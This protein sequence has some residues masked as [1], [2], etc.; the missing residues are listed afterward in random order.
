MTILETTNIQKTIEQAQDT[1]LTKAGISSL[2]SRWTL[3]E[4]ELADVV[5]FLRE[6]SDGHSIAA[7]LLAHAA[8]GKKL[9]AKVVG[10]ALGLLPTLAEVAAIAGSCE[11]DVVDMFISAVESGRM[12]VERECLSLWY[13]AWLSKAL[14]P[15]E[16]LVAALRT[17]C[18]LRLNVESGLLIAD[19]AELIGDE[20]LIELAMPYITLS[21]T[22][23]RKGAKTLL[24]EF[25]STFEKP[26]L[27]MLDDKEYSA[28]PVG[29]FT[30]R[31]PVEKVGRND[32][33]PCGSGK[34][35]KKCCQQKDQTRLGAPSPVPGVTM[36]EY[37][38][39]A[40]RYMPDSEFDSLRPHDIARLPMK[41][42]STVQLIA[43]MTRFVEFHM[44]DK[45]QTVLDLMA[46]RK[47]LP[48]LLDYYRLD[49]AHEAIQC[50]QKDVFLRQEAKIQEN[51]VIDIAWLDD[52][53]VKRALIQP[54][55][56]TLDVLNKRIE[57][58][59]MSDDS[60]T[61]IEIAYAL[62]DLYPGLGIVFARGVLN[63]ERILDA[64]V[65]LESIEQSRDKLLLPPGDPAAEYYDFILDRS[66]NR[67][68]AE[69]HSRMQSE[70]IDAL[71]RQTETLQNE[72]KS[73]T[74]RSEILAE[75][76]LRRTKELEKASE[77]SPAPS[78]S[79]SAVARDTADNANTAQV[80]RLRQKVNKLKSHI[81]E[82]RHEKIRLRKELAQMGAQFENLKSKQ[83]DPTDETSN[84]NEQYEYEAALPVFKEPLVPAFEKTATDAM[85]QLP[86]NVVSR[87][88][89]TVSAIA[90]GDQ[91]NAVKV[92]RIKKF[93]GLWSARVG[94]H[95]RILFRISS[96]SPRE[97]RVSH[98]IHRREL[99]NLLKKQT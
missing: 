75:E 30:V 93:E 56:Q 9:P 58:D 95:H 7:V 61:T 13:A 16:R 49:V 3:N 8:S 6:Q 48:D 37:L 57:R 85:A 39:N 66:L 47:D 25:A 67:H 84:D 22:S 20:H 65:L 32:P 50:N 98:I 71:T 88:I 12:A 17:R 72:I 60:N 2:A 83:D 44:W 86:Q 15:N 96:T 90:T 26:V 5:A 29:Q 87:S 94:I 54:D 23:Y 43:A 33:C 42:F 28:S 40:H 21:K 77:Q 99:E 46:E 24:A 82:I 10:T 34:K 76:L 79:P 74:A 92:S 51:A 14:P 91:T 52:L 45:A 59:L 27:E 97:I 68:I 62:M 31:R 80:G 41:E 19:A 35:Y 89:T 4:S 63:P 70:K 81:E 64:E 36:D 53:R 69:S 18:R 11:G 1:S 78:P 55:E 38:S 73:A